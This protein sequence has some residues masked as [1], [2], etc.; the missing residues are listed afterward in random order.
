MLRRILL[1]ALAVA[2][3]TSPIFAADGAESE[4]ED[5]VKVS[6]PDNIPVIKPAHEIGSEPNPPHVVPTEPEE[7]PTED[8]EK[9]AEIT[10][11]PAAEEPK[12]AIEKTLEM[13]DDEGPKNATAIEEETATEKATTLEVTDTF[14][15]EVTAE[16][17][18]QT[19][20]VITTEPP[21]TTS[22][23]FE[24]VPD[25]AE[26]KTEDKV[27]ESATEQP[28]FPVA[29]VAF[30]TEE[31][32]EE[33]KTTDN[34]FV[35]DSSL[36][37]QEATI[38]TP[39][40][41]APKIEEAPKEEK[42]ATIEFPRVQL[43]EGGAVE[44]EVKET[45]SPKEEVTEEE[46][47]FSVGTPPTVVPVFIPNSKPSNSPK[48][49]GVAIPTELDPSPSP[50]PE[51]KAE[52]EPASEPEPKPEPSTEPASNEK[53]ALE[54]TSE[55]E[56]K[57]EPEPEP[58]PEP[59]P[60]PKAE[61]EP[62][63]EPTTEPEPKAEPEPEPK[64]EPEP[65]PTS[66]P[67]PKAEPEPEPKAEP[68]PEP[69]P[70]NAV[71]TP[72]SVRFPGI[73]FSSDFEDSSSGRFRKLREQIEPELKTIFRSLLYDNYAGIDI[74]SMKKGSVIV[75]GRVHTLRRVDDVE[76]L[77]TQFE[78]K[79]ADNGAKLGGNDVDLH[80]VSVSGF[81]SKNA[82]E[83]VAEEESSQ[84]NSNYIIIGGITIAVLVILL[85][86]FTVIA[87]NN[88]RHN[89]T[90]KLKEEELNMAENGR[91]PYSNGNVNLMGYGSSPASNG[92]G[93]PSMVTNLS[94]NE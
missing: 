80:S 81:M 25:K 68:S 94:V 45:A 43:P 17:P 52:P 4:E 49:V 88:R 14:A 21:T 86:A 53:V 2:F 1:V 63:P 84:S 71:K 20:K 57:S 90:L 37:A 87:M 55:P 35:G 65:E 60:E 78:Q 93:A 33:D 69:I 5:S 74:V 58:K 92:G 59:E 51:P 44:E 41:V 31:P 91:S 56:P 79:I 75:E 85:I 66:E 40:E 67:E 70:E 34:V 73:D 26:A 27:A 16:D 32:S 42:N 48:P 15:P 77:A 39:A 50:E 62:S 12:G 6:I 8:E 22:E 29:A 10:E 7:K 72:F 9:T 46:Q 11:N 3:L 64:A 24:E 30:T 82:V 18:F 28:M 38:K 61:P 23:D 19:T 36:F 89:R 76:N 47:G 54:P 83:G 13:N